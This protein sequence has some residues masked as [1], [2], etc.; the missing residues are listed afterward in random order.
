MWSPGAIVTTSI[1][2]AILVTPVH[3]QEDGSGAARRPERPLIVTRSWSPVATVT[4]A[5]PVDGRTRRDDLLARAHDRAFLAAIAEATASDPVRVTYQRDGTGRYFVAV[6]DPGIA[7]SV[8]E[9]MRR[10]ART[11]PPGRLVD[12]A[13]LA[14]RNDMA[15]R[16][17]LPRSQ[18]D[19]AFD[20]QLR[21]EPGTEVGAAPA[22]PGELEG[23]AAEVAAMT[24][25]ERWSP[26]VWVV[27]GDSQA[28]PAGT[29]SGAAPADTTDTSDPP[30]LP[31]APRY[32]PDSS[33]PL[34]T[35]VPSDA[36]TR[37]IASVFR[38]PP[39]TTLVQATL[40]QLV[41]EESL[42]RRRDPDLY[43][44]DIQIDAL[45]RLVV[46]FSTSA[47]AASRW[48]SRL[49]EAIEELGSPGADVRL[50]E[51]LRPAR[52]R[53]SQ[54]LAAP[55]GAGLAAAQAL[56]R[57]A[58][59]VQATAFAN[60]ATDAP[61]ADQLRE[62]AGGLRLTIRLVYGT[63]LKRTQGSAVGTPALMQ[64]TSVLILGGVPSSVRLFDSICTYQGVTQ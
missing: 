59:P 54:V 52:S 26:P 32:S 33:A 43:E 11:G 12:E 53:W 8:L 3:S 55:A 21:G 15:F 61:D 49:D 5:L 51:L 27:V 20:A 47:D 36:V 64:L 10:I 58:S 16:G 31:V 22:D 56:L 46:R 25:A 24:P 1:A 39:E 9:A 41:L 37:W 50:N 42:D 30:P 40:L 44:L 4:M 48:E 13:V 28:I 29:L 23:L 6:S 57:G 7:A 35:A 45:G 14:L 2:C 17:D 19:R 60:S 34:H 62:A 18:F 63:Q 38:F